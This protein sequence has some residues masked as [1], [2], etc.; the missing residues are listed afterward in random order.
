MIFNYISAI[1]KKYDELLDFKLGPYNATYFMVFGLSLLLSLPLFQISELNLHQSIIKLAP[2]FAAFSL[3]LEEPILSKFEFTFNYNLIINLSKRGIMVLFITESCYYFTQLVKD[4]KRSKFKKLVINIL[5]A[6][7]LFEF[8]IRFFEL[9]YFFRGTYK[10]KSLAINSF[11]HFVYFIGRVIY[12][13]NYQKYLYLKS[14]DN[15][16]IEKLKP[17]NEFLVTQTYTTIQLLLAVTLFNVLNSC[18][19]RKVI[20]D[21]AINLFY[22][23]AI[24]TRITFRKGRSSPSF[25]DRQIEKKSLDN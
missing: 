10:W 6:L 23:F 2:F 1:G 21:T 5:S 9:I 3:F 24:V 20:D 25:V 12:D 16:K 13:T 19:D 8:L 15:K 14:D 22:I 18:N 17:D 4:R 11:F 7:D